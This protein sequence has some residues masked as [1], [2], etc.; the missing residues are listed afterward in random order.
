MASV[1]SN[2]EADRIYTR[3][4]R[5]DALDEL[6][7]SN[8]RTAVIIGG[9]PGA[10]KSLSAAAVRLHLGRTV[11]AALSVS[12]D[13]LREYH[14][15]WRDAPP[16][17]V[18][19]ATDLRQ[20][21]GRWAARLTADAIAAGVNVVVSSTLRDARTV[22][23]LLSSFGAAGYEVAA[24]V[25]A[26][27]RDRSRQATLA[28]YEAARWAGLTPRFVPSSLHDTAYARVPE[29]LAQLEAGHLLD[30]LQVITADGK[31]LYA[32][33]RHGSGWQQPARGAEVLSEFRDR[34]P[35][36]REQADSALRWQLIAQRLSTDDAVPREV[37]S[38]AVAWANEAFEALRRDPEALRLFHSGQEAQAFRTLTRAHFMR[39]FPQH[40]RAVERLDEAVRYAEKSFPLAVDRERFV[41]QARERIAERIA[42]GRLGSREREPQERAPRT[43]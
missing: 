41:E 39:E 35:T 25:L 23:G 12:A 34:R 4:I 29:T 30:R 1:L 2:R 7:P 38:Q 13:E 17:D 33:E 43:R 18:N 37:A 20:D 8:H 22:S 26:T 40:A 21:V 36:A 6:R 16:S 42:E 19:A 5:A 27:D 11:G 9:Q 14:P 32:N 3:L 24:V 28:R 31:Q 15:R 10:G